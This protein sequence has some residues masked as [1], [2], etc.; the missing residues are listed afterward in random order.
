[1]K[2]EKNL[3]PTEGLSGRLDDQVYALYGL[4]Q[5]EIKI[6]ED[7]FSTRQR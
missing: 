2:S 3:P 4:T 1:M 6:V 5:E 7:S